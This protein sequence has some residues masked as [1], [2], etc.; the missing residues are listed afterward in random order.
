MECGVDRRVQH[1]QTDR[2]TSS[3]DRAIVHRVSARRVLGNGRVPC[4]L[5][6]GTDRPGHLL[7]LSLIHFCFCQPENRLANVTR[8]EFLPAKY[9][10]AEQ[11]TQHYENRLRVGV[12]QFLLP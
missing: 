3:L 6:F 11:A 2:G 1:G 9:P 7:A 5:A 10:A 4:G 12:R 8:S